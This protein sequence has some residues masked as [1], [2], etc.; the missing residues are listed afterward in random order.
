M[1]TIHGASSSPR[2]ALCSA[3][4]AASSCIPRS[5]LSAFQTLPVWLPEFAD[6]INAIQAR[7]FDL[8]PVVREHTYHPAYAGS[9][10]IKS[11]LP[12]LVPEMTYDG[13]AVANGQDAGLAWES[14]VTGR[15][16]KAESDTIKKALLEYCG[17][18]TLA[19][20]KVLEKL[21]LEGIGCVRKQSGRG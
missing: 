11:V 6:Q 5:S 14:L 15:L 12:A 21:K 20:V 16:D 9:Y 4:A 10:S 3:K 18:D 7:L 13:M 17:R 1:R 8:L 2:F 19:L